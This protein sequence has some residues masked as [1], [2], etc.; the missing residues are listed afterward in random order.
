MPTSINGS[1]GG[2]A[3]A[4]AGTGVV[5]ATGGAFVTPVASAAT[6][7]AT[8]DA[9]QDVFTTR[10]DLV[11]AGV[12]GVAERVAIGTATHVLTSD[13]TDA[14][15]AAP[16]G[17][18]PSGAAGGDLGGTYPNPTV[19]DLTIASET[20]GDLLRR[21]ATTWERVA[22]KTSGH[23]V[24]GDGTD[25]VAAAIATP[26][27][28]DAS[29]NRT[30]LG[31]GGAALLAVGT[32]AGTVAAGDDSRIT[33]AIAAST[34][35]TR[36]DLIRRGA[37]APERVALGTNGQVLTSNGTDAVWS[38]PG[39]G[40]WLSLYGGTAFYLGGESATGWATADYVTA[41]A[42][43]TVPA[44]GPG[45]SIVICLMP[46]ATPS[47]T[48]MIA[49]HGASG[50]RGWVVDVGRQ[51]GS[52]R[53][54]SVYLYGLNSSV[55]VALTGS[56]FTVGTAYVIAIT[57]KADKSLRYSTNGGAV[58][59]IAALSGAYAVPT[60]T[61]T[62]NVGSPREFS[63]SFFP[64]ASALLGEVRTYSTEISDDD[65]VA[66]CAN[67]ATGTIAD[68]ATGTVSTRFL[69]SDFVGGVRVKAQTGV[70][71]LLKGGVSIR[72]V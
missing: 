2:G 3:S 4:P 41:S 12:G 59:T 65:L 8:L 40:S 25:V 45:Q 16:S 21:G 1:T 19:T 6:T 68:V 48:E 29:G 18:A 46:L 39:G 31:L 72:P 50:V 47:G 38:T 9:M 67:V 53:Q 43:S 27:A 30:A 22:A 32:T 54:V 44:F 70:T 34:L 37:S 51:S 33:G 58:Q 62:Y 55:A 13:G 23:V 69:P 60:I 35:T 63:P 52:R 10:G 36:G 28:V 5:T 42:A 7:R 20:R 61:D 17:G 26:L 49:S 57:I 15:W 24:C 14:G 56:E 66:A 11:R 71:W 64:L